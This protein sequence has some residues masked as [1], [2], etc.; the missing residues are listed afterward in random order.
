MRGH[1]SEENL[2]G[3]R[4]N[5]VIEIEEELSG[6]EL[7]LAVDERVMGWQRNP[8]GMMHGTPQEVLVQENGHTRSVYCGCAEDWNPAESIEAAM[9]V[10]EKI[11]FDPTGYA[12]T[13]IN[14]SLF[15]IHRYPDGSWLAHFSGELKGKAYAP[16][17]PEA[18]CRAALKAVGSE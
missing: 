11:G 5:V 1:F 8:N 4:S 17:L 15:S 9:E 2:F 10:V 13:A 3:W 16:T 14:L 12:Q 7:S 18:I 6:K